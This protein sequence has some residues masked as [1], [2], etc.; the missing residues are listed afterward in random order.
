VPSKQ[1]RQWLVTFTAGLPLYP[2]EAISDAA[3]AEALPGEE[4]K[5]AVLQVA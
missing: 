1:W 3:L 4:E 5:I 2:E